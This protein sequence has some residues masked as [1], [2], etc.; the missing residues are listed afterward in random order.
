M[1]RGGEV[2]RGLVLYPYMNKVVT[3]HD[4]VTG[5]VG[6]GGCRGR[7]VCCLGLRPA[8]IIISG[9]RVIGTIIMVR[10]QRLLRIWSAVLASRG[11]Q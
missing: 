1:M 4:F 3:S 8:Y 2:W 6:E 10:K 9:M 5:V 11:D 7:C